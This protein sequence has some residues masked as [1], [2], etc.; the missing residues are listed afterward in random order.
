MGANGFGYLLYVL[1]FLLIVT[2]V[3][4]IV[5]TTIWAL[6]RAKKDNSPNRRD[7]ALIS[8]TFFI[9]AAASFIFNIGWL[10]LIATFLL[11]P[12][13]GTIAFFIMNFFAGKYIDKSNYLKKL[14][15]FFMLTY[16]AGNIF[17]PDGGDTGGMYFF[18]GLIHNDILS[19]L[20]ILISLG[21]FVAN[22]VLFILQFVEIIQIRK[23]IPK[24]L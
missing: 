24:K 21:A 3:L 16:L 20:A 13:T 22:I 5:G 10:R 18:F 1:L 2:S 12:F 9:F 6:I 11:V 15:L 14:N 7:I 23:N 17:S 4:V 19:I 8:L